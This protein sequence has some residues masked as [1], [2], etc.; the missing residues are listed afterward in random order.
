LWSDRRLTQGCRRIRQVAVA[1][2]PATS[3]LRL[4]RLMASGESRHSSAAAYKCA[5]N[6]NYLEKIYRSSKCSRFLS[7][8]MDRSELVEIIRLLLSVCVSSRVCVCVSV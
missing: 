6:N 7:P 1:I 5:K 4:E 3:V 2:D 8:P